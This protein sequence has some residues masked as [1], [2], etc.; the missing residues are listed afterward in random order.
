LKKLSVS[1]QWKIWRFPIVVIMKICIS[2]SSD[3]PTVARTSY[4]SMRWWCLL[5]IRSTHGHIILIS[6]QLSLLLVLNTEFLAESRKYKFYNLWFDPTGAWTYYY[7]YSVLRTKS[8]DSWLEIRIMC[9]CVDLIT[10]RHHHLIE[11]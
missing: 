9:P 11:M 3:F 8:N 7:V 6:S 5:V 10:S 2:L 4:I 1:L